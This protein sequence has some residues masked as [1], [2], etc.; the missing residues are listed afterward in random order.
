MPPHNKEVIMSTTA[1][2][3]S[4]AQIRPFPTPFTAP[5]TLKG[6]DKQRFLQNL[7]SQ[8]QEEIEAYQVGPFLLHLMQTAQQD[9]G[10]K[11]G[12]EKQ[13]WVCQIFT[14]VLS[15]IFYHADNQWKKGLLLSSAESLTAC[16]KA[17]ACNDLARAPFHQKVTQATLPIKKTIITRSFSPSVSVTVDPL[18]QRVQLLYDTFQKQVQKNEIAP[19]LLSI[20]LLARDWNALSV[21]EH[22]QLREKLARKV[23]DRAFSNRNQ[24]AIQKMA[25]PIL[26]EL[27]PVMFHVFDEATLKAGELAQ[28]VREKCCKCSSCTIL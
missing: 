1:I 9:P 14:E 11:G 17:L 24:D 3:R 2:H 19:L 10:F 18:E 28:L 26:V 4:L 23:L 16:C 20:Y 21:E 25:Y 7:I 15:Q 8:F 27:V 6:E 13:E 5:S 12:K 22:K